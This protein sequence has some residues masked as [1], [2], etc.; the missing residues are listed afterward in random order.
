[1]SIS[2]NQRREP[3]SSVERFFNFSLVFDRNVE[4]SVRL[5]KLAVGFFFCFSDGFPNTLADLSDESCV[6]ITP[7]FC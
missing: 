7:V 3:D 5:F 2:G 6:C 1:M 4:L